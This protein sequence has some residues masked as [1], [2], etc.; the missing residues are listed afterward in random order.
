M[1]AKKSLFL[2]AISLLIITTSC[3]RNDRVEPPKKDNSGKK[4]ADM[5]NVD[6]SDTDKNVSSKGSSDL[7]EEIISRPP[8]PATEYNR[9]ALKGNGTV[10]G[11]IYVDDGNGEKIYGQNTRL[12]LNP[13]TSYSRQWYNESYVKGYKLTKADSRLYNY[14]KFTTSDDKGNFAFYGIPSGS[15][16]VIGSVSHGAHKVRIAE[17]IYVGNR[18]IVKTAL[19]RGIE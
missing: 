10:T 6:V 8:F 13:V 4:W 18:G 19:S 7:R 1:V 5:T 16:Y 12:Y 2:L 17:K 11:V 3:S 14:M 9:L 15:Y